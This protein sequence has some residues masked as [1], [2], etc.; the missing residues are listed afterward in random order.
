MS[1]FQVSISRGQPRCWAL[2]LLLALTGCGKPAETGPVLRPVQVMVVGG[3][4]AAT[5]EVYSGEIRSRLETPL[6]FRVGGQLLERKVD[7]GQTVKAGEVLARLDV[8]DQ[9]L[10]ASAALAQAS[11]AEADLRRYRELRGRNFV[12]QAALDAKETAYKAAAAQSGVA[13]N[14]QGYTTLRAEQGGVIAAV[15]AEVGQVVTPGQAVFRLARADQP[16]VAIS[17]SEGRVSSLKPGMP[18]EISLWS[19]AAVT[20]PGKIREVSA[21]AEMPA[22]TYAVRVS[23]LQPDARLRLGQSANVRLSPSTPSSLKIPLSAV[24]QSNNAPAVWRVEKSAEG[25]ET[26][27]LQPIQVQAWEEDGARLATASGLDAGQRIVRAG[28]HKL[29]EGE[30]I[31]AVA[32]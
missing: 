19:D 28:V 29:T 11:L 6:S 15:L 17:V 30:T 1:C 3:E 24:F 7:V 27:R 25:V 16:E 20:L 14:Q 32:P 9:Q 10:N 31:R 22:R 23:V 18:A 26:V 2:A 21:V 4:S 13:A 8:R 12:S 5:G